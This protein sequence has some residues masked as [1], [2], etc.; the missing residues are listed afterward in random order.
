MAKVT[1]RLDYQPVYLGFDQA[2][3]QLA[4]IRFWR[5]ATYQQKLTAMSEFIEEYYLLFAREKN[6]QEFLR[7]TAVIKFP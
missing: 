6:E 4:E 1:K 2:D 7:S 3:A 5:E